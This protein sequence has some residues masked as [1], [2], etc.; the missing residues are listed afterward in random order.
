MA[1]YLITVRCICFMWTEL[2]AGLLAHTSL[3]SRQQ[4]M[5]PPTW[6]TQAPGNGLPPMSKRRVHSPEFKAL[7]EGFRLC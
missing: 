6:L 4:R 2:S 1:I 7:A 3:D 5:D